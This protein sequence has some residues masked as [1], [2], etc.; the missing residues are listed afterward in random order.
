M[1]SGV[2]PSYI[3]YHGHVTVVSGRRRLFLPP[4]WRRSARD[5]GVVTA[6]ATATGHRATA[7]VCTQGGGER[8]RNLKITRPTKNLL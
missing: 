4:E 8:D 7:V 5:D 2:G 3:G 6:L 1:I